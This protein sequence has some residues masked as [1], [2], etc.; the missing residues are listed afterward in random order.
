MLSFLNSVFLPALAAVALPILI[1]LLTR[2]RLVERKW[3]SI[4]FL[5]EIQKR[6]MRKFKLKQLLL[7]ALRVLILLFVISAFAR[8]TIRTERSALVGTHERTSV[9]I[10]IDNSYSMGQESAGIDLFTQARQAA[11]DILELLSDGDEVAIV[12]FNSSPMP[13][14]REPFKALSAAREVID[15][16]KISSGT[17]DVW[18][19]IAKGIDILSTSKLPN[20]EIYLL[21]DDKDHGWQRAGDLVLPEGVKIYCLIFSPD[22]ERNI[23]ISDIQFPRTLLQK[24]VPF[25]LLPEIMSFAPGGV[26]DFV[27]DLYLDDVRV[28]QRSIDLAPGDL[29]T[30]EFRSQVDEGGF[31]YGEFRTEGDA[32]PADNS[33]W[34]SFKIPELIRVLIVGGTETRF[35]ANALS[36]SGDDFFDVK[37]IS[38]AQ[39]GAELLSSWDVVILSD[40]P[41]LAANLAAS[42]NGFISRGGG[43][44]LLLGGS[45]DPSRTW[46]SLF[47][48]DT[49]MSVVA[50]IGDSVGS[51]RFKIGNADFDHPI[52]TPFADEGLP[53][54]DF[55]RVAAI[56]DAELISLYLTNNVPLIAEREVGEGKLAVCAFSASLQFGELPTS[57]FFVPLMHR[58]AQYLAS[59]VSEFDRGYTVGDDVVR[60]IETVGAG[61]LT[62]ERPDGSR[63]F[64]APRFSGG[65]TI[66]PVGR[67]STPGI[68]SVLNN[69]ELVDVFAVNVD[70]RESDPE[71]LDKRAIERAVDVHWLHPDRDIS[72]EILSARHGRELHH[73]FLVIAFF[74]MLAELALGATWR[75]PRNLSAQIKDKE[76]L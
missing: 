1:H 26:S 6:R 73:I 22:D 11:E 41:E 16:L 7:L 45:P 18:G 69:E 63:T 21:T 40:P 71:K 57:G 46:K 53:D 47:G 28:A 59:D 27:V 48:E 38:Y 74:L 60:I 43:L 39:L 9:A 62:L 65:R 64:I 67:V 55:R 17:T 51:A 44:A 50:S 37:R 14:S 56:I 76:V 3:P 36:P 31:H 20:R 42:I 68:Y 72:Q 58:L 23:G 66:L 12:P 8:P 10:L 4:R 61:A 2:R 32:L 35:I 15:T 34:F 24:R 52:F 70:V 5:E 54:V 33:R 19:A 30:L 49:G 75:K 25:N 13:A 29:A